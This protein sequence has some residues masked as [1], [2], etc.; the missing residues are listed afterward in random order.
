MIC[1]RSNFRLSIQEVP[2]PGE[3]AEAAA[4]HVQDDAQG[5]P[6]QGPGTTRTTHT[7]VYI[8]TV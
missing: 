4:G 3:G 2:G 8:Q 6:R 1:D 7:A 5:A